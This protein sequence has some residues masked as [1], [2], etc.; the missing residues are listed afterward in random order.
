[1]PETT[2]KSMSSA[3]LLTNLI[4]DGKA[5][6]AQKKFDQSVELITGLRDIDIK[7]SEI[8]INEAVL[9]PRP[10]RRPAKICIFASGD[11]AMRAKRAGSDRVVEP[12][13]I[14]RLAGD[15]TARKKLC[16]QFDFFLAETSLMAKIG[17]VLGPHLG[18]K[19]K[20]PIPIQRDA[21][22][23]NLLSRFRSSIRVRSRGQMAVQAKIGD[24]HMSEED[25]VEN[26]RAV[27]SAIERKL[28]AGEKNLARIMIKSTMSR[29]V[30]MRVTAK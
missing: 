21:P 16:R 23:E 11:L 15:K 22:V 9:L 14:D 30:K 29:P 3:D 28:P 7:K 8:N 20:M 5:S 26:A 4:R 2:V 17:K 10:L 13:E 24:V 19:G 12:D 27:L 25:L 18:P 1:M 6:F